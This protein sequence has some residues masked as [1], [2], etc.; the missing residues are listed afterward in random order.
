LK[1]INIIGA[2]ISGLAA[3][4]Y[5]Q[6]NGFETEIFERNANA[7]GLCTSWKKG[8][9][10]FD[11]GLQWLLGSGNSSQ[12][13][14]LWSELVD[15]DAI[16]FVNHDIWVE[17]GTRDNS[18]GQ[19]NKIFHLYT[20][21][22]ILQEYM[23]GISPQDRRHI[24]KFIYSMR[25]IQRYEIPPMIKSVPQTMSFLEKMQYARHLPLLLFLYR[26]KHVTNFRFARK[27]KDPFLRE[28]FELLFDGADL[29]LIIISMPL[30]F[31]DSKGAG[32]PV[33]G[34]A[35]FTK[36]M[37]EKYLSLGGKI[38]YHGEVNRIITEKDAAVGLLLADGTE[39]LSDITISS[40][41]WHYTI[42]EALEGK[43]TDATILELEAEKRLPI[44]YSVFMVS[45]GIARTFEG[46]PHYSRYSLDKP[47]VSPDGTTYERLEAH[48]YNYDPTLAPAGK[49]VISFSFYSKNGQFW[50]D[51]RKRDYAEYSRLKKEFAD[52]VIEIAHD[53]FSP[54][55]EFIE[56]TDI[57]TPATYHRYS[58][59]WKGSTQ[60]WLVGKNLMSRPPVQPELP[61]LKNFYFSGHWTVPG[62]GLPIA[63]KS[64]RDVAKII[65]YREHKKFRIT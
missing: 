36:R 43:Y 55:K 61:G 14:K 62:G 24:R 26:W 44:F 16:E 41:D 33:G 9:Y 1:K 65:C 48:I 50:I 6:M 58:N 52:K 40:A 19:G 47:L 56:E 35:F 10:T 2:G 42:F 45:L 7:G 53:K 15:M 5:L 22:R 57:A 23:T 31:F 59:N 25:K 32:Y 30:A 12:F 3:G 17:I 13:H 64:A 39:A 63:V 18:D 37:V 27:F 46:F 4:S 28:A 60:G 8:D 54:F 51:L 34:S 29:P 11:G 49:T 38:R 20:D 21:L